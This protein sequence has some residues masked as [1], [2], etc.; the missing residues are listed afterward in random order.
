MSHPSGI[1]LGG[2]TA[3]RLNTD[4]HQIERMEL[5]LR[6]KVQDA[7]TA[8]SITSLVHGVFS[9]DDL[10]NKLQSDL[11]A[12]IGVGVGYLRTEPTAL[13]T[14]AKAHLNVGGGVAVKTLDFYFMVILAVPTG[15]Q[16]NE[17][18]HATQVLTA[19]R[20]GIMG[21]TVAGDDSNR[22][23]A[24]VQ[25]APNVSES[26]DTMLYYSQVWRLAMQNVGNR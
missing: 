6:K 2:V 23:W 13:V 8:H 19:L 22:K 7:L 9:L 12:H 26:T 4:I 5:D 15:A 21:S 10:E 11:C 25:E 24:F 16:C 14:D 3:D 17:V 18:H 20:F 1:A